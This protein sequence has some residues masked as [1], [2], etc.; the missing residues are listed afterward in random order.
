MKR[1]LLTS[2]L[3]AFASIT[4]CEAK[5]ESVAPGSDKPGTPPVTA[6]RTRI[7]GN[8]RGDEGQVLAL[9]GVHVRMAGLEPFEV[10]VGDDGHFELELPRMGW[11]TLRMTGV[12][13]EEHRLGLLATG[14]SHQLSVTLGTYDRAAELEALEGFGQFGGQANGQP[15][16]FERREDGTWAATVTPPD[17]PASPLEFRYQLS[18][19]TQEGHTINGT[20]ADR[21]AYDGDGDYFSV[22]DRSAAPSEGFEIV[23]DPGALPRAGQRV[24]VRFGDPSS[25]LARA[26][27][28]S[29]ELAA[30]HEQAWTQLGEAIDAA[31][32]RDHEALRARSRAELSAK[33]ATAL[34]LE[35]DPVIQRLMLITWVG[36]TDMRAELDA[37]ELALLA[38]IDRELGPRD[39]L[40][41]IDVWAMS[42]VLRLAPDPATF[43]VAVAEHPDA[44]VVAALWAEEV[45][46]AD[47]AGDRARG[48]V[49]MNALAQPRFADTIGQR[50]AQIYDPERPTAP[51]RTVPDF[52][53]SSVDGTSEFSGLDLRGRIYVLD[54]WATWCGPCVAEMPR[55]HAAYAEL[56]G[57]LA[58]AD[59][60]EYGAI[61]EPKLEIFSI[62]FD[63]D[64]AKVAKFRAEVWPMPWVHAVPDAV[65]HA[66]LSDAFGIVGIPTMLLVGADGTILASSP[67]LDGN[68]LGEIARPYL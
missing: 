26:A 9:A 1:T 27:A 38:R 54:F 35:S 3:A 19:A 15:L 48:R 25:L 28:R 2:V 57:Q 18:N 23:L 60:L 34:A 40:W 32:E 66:Q 22:I 13:H 12:D 55:L 4:A 63:H 6:E 43:A 8:L 37:I 64:P 61:P 47:R 65:A 24:S 36:Q 56:N 39:P 7:H 10:E 42:E 45:I 21:F 33:F 44:N 53:L 50:L 67:H 20:Q 52:R 41:S 62:S 68:N 16:R 30:W 29:L 31:P 14:G 17:S 46:T 49:A 5:T 51:G 59:K 11:V 58:Q